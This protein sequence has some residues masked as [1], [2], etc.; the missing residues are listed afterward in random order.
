MGLIRVLR[1][2]TLACD[3]QYN[4][5]RQKVSES[6]KEILQQIKTNMSIERHQPFLTFSDRDAPPGVFYIFNIFSFCT[7]TDVSKGELTLLFTPQLS[8]VQ[9]R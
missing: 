7:F 1:H 9:A 5:Q 8:Y 2:T 4:T 6:D 3:A